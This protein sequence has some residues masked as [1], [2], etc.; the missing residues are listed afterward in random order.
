MAAMYNNIVSHS[1]VIQEQQVM[2]P[3]INQKPR[4]SNSYVPQGLMSTINS[5][6]IINKT[7]EMYT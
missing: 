6:D 7:K 1:M 5:D 2:T 4:F 3:L